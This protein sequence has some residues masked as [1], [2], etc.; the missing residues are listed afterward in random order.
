MTNQLGC[1][2]VL[3]GPEGLMNP[4]TGTSSARRAS[5]KVGKAAASELSMTT[6]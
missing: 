2:L 6:P 5:L 4:K 1:H 3:D